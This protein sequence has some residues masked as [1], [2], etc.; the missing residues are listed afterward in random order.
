MPSIHTL[1]IQEMYLKIHTVLSCH[2][3]YYIPG[4]P[5]G[6]GGRLTLPSDVVVGI[7]ANVSIGDLSSESMLGEKRWSP[8]LL[9]NTAKIG[10]K[11]CVSV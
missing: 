5:Q 6:Q 2:L 9:W 4:Q 1:T 10:I 8:I 3:H 11:E 7:I